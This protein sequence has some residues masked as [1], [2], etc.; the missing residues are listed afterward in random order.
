MFFSPVIS[1]IVLMLIFCAIVYFV[2][3]LGII[4]SLSVDLLRKLISRMM[5]YVSNG[6]LNTAHSRVFGQYNSR[7]LGVS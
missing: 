6:T 4:V 7:A 2:F 1:L 5:C 3:L